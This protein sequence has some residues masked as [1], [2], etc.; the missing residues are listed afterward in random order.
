MNLLQKF[1]KGEDSNTY[2]RIDSYYKVNIFLG[3]NEDGQMSMVITEFGKIVNIKSTKI[4]QVSLKC[5]VDGKL[6]LSFDLID[7]AYKS[8][9]L[10]FC[11]DI[12]T[13]CEKVGNE[14]AI[15]YAVTRW[16]YWQEMFGRRKHNLLNKVEI[17][18]LIGELIE[19]KNHFMKEND[20]RKAIECW[21]GPL[22]G[23][24]D[25]EIGNTWYEV[26]SVNENAIQININSLEQLEAEYEGHLVVVRLEDSNSTTSNSINLNGIVA[27]IIEQ[28]QEIDVIKIFQKK[29]DSIGYNYNTEYDKYNFI[30]KGTQK[31]KVNDEFPRIRRSE[32]S[33]SV[34]NVQYSLLLDGLERFREM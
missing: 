33:L 15:S 16:K 29:L 24:K 3:Y 12:I 4:I 34:G 18:G 32:L 14:M 10:V 19:L 27:D 1:Q 20:E 6:A 5:R 31:Y 9:F 8:L 25:F 21:M 13:T 23:H 28:I 26:K 7:N 2:Q 22:F 30:Y 17:K 11:K